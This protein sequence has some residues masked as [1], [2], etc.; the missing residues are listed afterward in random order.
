M[1]PAKLLLSFDIEEFD[2]PEEYGAFI[3]IDDK[4]EISRFGTEQLLTLLEQMQTPATF[5][6]T[7]KFA[8]RSPELIKKMVKDGHEVASH[9]MNH[10]FFELAHLEE[11]KNVL[12]NISGQNV[13]GF[14]MARL[15]P[16]D[17]GEIK[18]AGFVYESSLNPV[19]LP[20]HYC[21]LRSPLLPFKESCGLWQFP[22]SAVPGIRFPLFWLSFKNLPLTVYKTAA[23]AA[24]KLTGYYNMYSHP[25]E[26][27]IQSRSKEWKIPAFVVRH[28][29]EKQL[30]RLQ[31]LIMSLAGKGKFMTFSEFLKDY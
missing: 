24:I 30:L 23:A 19:W 14:R 11:S 17:K 7:G 20:G 13:T 26:Y 12:E 5:F 22:V 28:A 29:G 9:G 4:F 2:L 31:K 3:S 10:S 27:N 16:V 25:W 8:I 18:A 1:K 21:N 15:A 6:V